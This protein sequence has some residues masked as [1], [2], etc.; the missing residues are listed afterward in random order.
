M[1]DFF[2]HL[3]ALD[4]TWEDREA[5]SKLASFLTN[6]KYEL[7]QKIGTFLSLAQTEEEFEARWGLCSID[8][9]S[10]TAGLDEDSIGTLKESMK[11]QW[12]RPSGAKAKA[13]PAKVQASV[14]KTSLSFEEFKSE[15]QK[16]M[17]A[18]LTDSEMYDLYDSG[19]TPEDAA[20][21]SENSMPQGGY[22]PTNPDM[23]FQEDHEDLPSWTSSKLGSED[24]D[25]EE[26][27]DLGE[28][29]H[30]QATSKKASTG[31]TAAHLVVKPFMA[32]DEDF[33]SPGDAGLQYETWDYDEDQD[34]YFV[35]GVDPDEESEWIEFFE[36]DHAFGNTEMV[37]I[38]STR[39]TALRW[40]EPSYS[41]PDFPQWQGFDEQGQMVAEV[42][43]YE[44]MD[45]GYG[46][47]FEFAIYKDGVDPYTQDEGDHPTAQRA[48]EAADRW[49]SQN[50][51][52]TFSSLKTASVQWEEEDYKDPF[53][54]RVF[55]AVDESG[56]VV[57]T[58]EAYQDPQGDQVKWEYDVLHPGG[59]WKDG[60]L[61]D[62]MA[63]EAFEQAYGEFIK[64]ASKDRGTS[65][66]RL[67]FGSRTATSPEDLEVGATYRV[68]PIPVYENGQHVKDVRGS[69]TV[70]EVL[71]DDDLVLGHWIYDDPSLEDGRGFG[72]IPQSDQLTKINLANT[73]KADS[74]EEY[75]NSY[76]CPICGP[77]TILDGEEHPGMAGGTESSMDLACGHT[78]I[79]DP[80]GGTSVVK[81]RKSASVAQ[82]GVLTEDVE[83][84]ASDGS[85]V[86]LQ[87]GT[88]VEVVEDD[89]NGYVIM[90]AD[91]EA[92]QPEYFTEEFGVEY[93]QV[94]LA[95]ARTAGQWVGLQ[96]PS[97]FQIDRSQP[98]SERQDEDW[99]AQTFLVQYD[100]LSGTARVLYQIAED[101]NSPTVEEEG[102]V[103]ADT[104][105]Q[106]IQKAQQEADEFL[107]AYSRVGS[108]NGRAFKK[109]AGGY[110]VG[111]DVMT[112]GGLARVVDHDSNAVVVEYSNGEEAFWHP[113]E[114]APMAEYLSDPSKYLAR[115]N[116]KALVGNFWGNAKSDA[117]DVYE[118][119][120]Q[121]GLV[122]IFD[123]NES[124]STRDN[125]VRKRVEGF[126]EEVGVEYS[127]QE[128]DQVFRE[129]IDIGVGQAKKHEEE[130]QRLWDEYRRNVGS[131]Q[132]RSFQDIKTGDT[133]L[134]KEDGEVVPFKV[135]SVSQGRLYGRT[136]RPES[137]GQGPWLET[138]WDDGVMESDWVP[139]FY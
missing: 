115:K 35:R 7:D 125:V 21:F 69:L 108:G 126:Q 57:G 91:S 38:G 42:T 70:E 65:R 23:P 14:Q 61:S 116:L 56:T 77:T 31:R 22:D 110:I 68:Y 131:S 41:T 17:V 67:P 124:T 1:S 8:L 133:V 11:A 132:P 19:L 94:R 15:T 44:D 84:S 114:L 101:P 63:K 97:P 136:D 81:T 82:Q 90:V 27:K 45:H 104:L 80:V 9:A 52:G 37:R 128:K 4:G 87:E 72:E 2:D 99:S 40:E 28:R 134:I 102:E 119:I 18:E 88:P 120:I 138:Y 50:V 112:P 129:V 92:V 103:E 12:F 16:L 135:E 5:S 113:E 24:E 46:Q 78:V 79:D 85:V 58:V 10:V 109:A 137:V 13:K 83:S 74:Y 49:W 66:S 71:W 86:R 121:G 107:Q 20:S 75:L 139:S 30:Q 95:S 96:T 123:S 32:D 98:L 62:D 89:G 76:E 59:P 26:A 105:T 93:N 51:G 106:A 48:M 43:P 47:V 111:D 6:A 64:H 130:N 25:E 54:Y 73:H 29:Y 60:F 122:Y 117:E 118:S 127:Q 55:Q 36:G 34:A 53:G 100:N 33:P 39:R 3:E